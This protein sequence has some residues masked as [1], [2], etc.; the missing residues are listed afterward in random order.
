[1]P[2]KLFCIVLLCLAVSIDSRTLEFTLPKGEYVVCSDDMNNRCT[3]PT[4]CS[5]LGQVNFPAGKNINVGGAYQEDGLW[6]TEGGYSLQF[7]SDCV[8]TCDGDCTCEMCTDVK[9]LQ[10]GSSGGSGAS[11]VRRPLLLSAFMG[12]LAL[13]AWLTL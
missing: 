10:K 3:A 11:S 9:V 12:V 13:G 8:V 1:M 2:A 5:S 6:V 4:K 7:P